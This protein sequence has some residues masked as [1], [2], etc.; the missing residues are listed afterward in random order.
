METDEVYKMGQRAHASGLSL[1]ANPYPPNTLDRRLWYDG[2]CWANLVS[3]RA[4]FREQP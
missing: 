3:F 1:S 4:K 2:W